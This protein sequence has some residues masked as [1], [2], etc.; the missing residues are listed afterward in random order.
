MPT[1]RQEHDAFGHGEKV[2]TFL[3]IRPIKIRRID[4]PYDILLVI[5]FF[6]ESY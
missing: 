3:F 6:I 4:I 1:L 2:K 5:I